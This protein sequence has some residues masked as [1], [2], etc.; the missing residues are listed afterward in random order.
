MEEIC[1]FPFVKVCDGF[2]R[3]GGDGQLHFIGTKRV[4]LLESDFI[5]HCKGTTR[6]HHMI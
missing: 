3:S 5:P 1:L 6:S 2:S 4:K